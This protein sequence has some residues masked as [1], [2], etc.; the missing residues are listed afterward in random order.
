MF[1]NVIIQNCTARQIFIWILTSVRN[2]C[3][4]IALSDE[5]N[6][7][8]RSQFRT[9]FDKIHPKCSH[10]FICR[11]EKLLILWIA[12]IV[13]N[14]F[15]TMSRNDNNTETSRDVP[16][17]PQIDEPPED[18]NHGDVNPPDGNPIDENIQLI[19]SPDN[20]KGGNL[21]LQIPTPHMF[22]TFCDW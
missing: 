16:P 18:N 19:E 11:W 6:I 12:T 4:L 9:I 20:R 21:T 2:W 10:N 15:A 7:P 5:W 13:S 8:K 14:C 17:D 1:S 22:W 3:V